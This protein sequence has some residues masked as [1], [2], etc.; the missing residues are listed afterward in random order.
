[1]QALATPSRL[2][3][4]ACLHEGSASVSEISAAVGMDGPDDAL[5]LAARGDRAQESDPRAAL[6][7]LGLHPTATAL[8]RWPFAPGVDYLACAILAGADANRR[9]PPWEDGAMGRAAG[10]RRRE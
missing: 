7:G 5:A 10:G 4:L 1:M 6:A 2:R 8:W 9:P 3:I